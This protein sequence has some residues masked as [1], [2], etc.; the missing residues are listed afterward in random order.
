MVI[1]LDLAFANERPR[2]GNAVAFILEKVL[3]NKLY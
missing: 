2:Q 3:N 1:I